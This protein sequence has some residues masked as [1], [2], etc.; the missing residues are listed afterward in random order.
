MISGVVDESVLLAS[1]G[2]DEFVG[3]RYDPER[4]GM[5]RRHDAAVTKMISE[6]RTRIP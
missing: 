3:D 4:H 2:Y 1:C 5:P 6:E